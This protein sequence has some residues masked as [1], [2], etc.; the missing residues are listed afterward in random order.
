MRVE[1]RVPLYLIIRVTLPLLAVG[2]AGVSGAYYRYGPRPLFFVLLFGVP[3]AVVGVARLIIVRRGAQRARR[4]KQRVEGALAAIRRARRHRRVQ[5]VELAAMRAAEDD[6]LLSPERVRTAAES[7]FRLVQS[8]W[9]VRD[10]ERLATLLGPA[11]LAEWEQRLACAERN[12]RSARLE[13]VGD[14]HVEYVGFSTDETGQGP[15]VVADRGGAR[16]LQGRSPQ[17]SHRTC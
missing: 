3:L 6:A 15:L 8:A 14:V 4:V 16:P 5:H 12:R 1:G 11:L 9:N 13:V 10:R 2:T 17:A 7:L